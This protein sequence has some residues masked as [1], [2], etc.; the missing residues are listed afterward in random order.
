MIATTIEIRSAVIRSLRLL[1]IALVGVCLG[2]C[3]ASPPPLDPNRLSRDDCLK[4]VR[5]DALEKALL[6]CDQVVA[7]F[8]Q[9]PQP[10][11][12][13]FVLHSLNED[14][15]AACR[16]IDQAAAL[17]DSGEV[18]GDPQLGIDVRVRQESCR[19]RAPLPQ[20]LR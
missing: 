19:E 9:D 5:V 12:D 6:A 14:P 1:V 16:D 8:P 2:A 20:S 13:R 18:D 7:Q 17:L 4:D 10:L 3:R 11:N 15:K